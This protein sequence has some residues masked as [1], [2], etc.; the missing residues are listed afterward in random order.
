MFPGTT[1][2]NYVFWMAMGALQILV[3]AGAYAWFHSYGKKV[4]WWQMLLMY[5]CFASF[6]LVIA[7]GFTLMGEYE[8]RAGWYFIGVL[9]LPPIIVEA[10]L[11]KLFLMKK[12]SGAA[13]DNAA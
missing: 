6:C 3:I 13:L 5:L 7:G 8:S 12:K 2:S 1:I 11:V 4:R 10:I 9:G